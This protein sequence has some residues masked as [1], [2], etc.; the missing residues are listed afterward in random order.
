MPTAGEVIGT[1]SQLEAVLDAG[2]EN[3][4]NRQEV[5]F[6]LYNKVVVARDSYVFWVATPRTTTVIGSLHY[7]S[8]RYQDEDQTISANQV[9]LSAEREITDLNAVAPGTMWIG[10]W[11][12]SP[13]G[14]SLP[15]QYL[16]VAFSQRGFLYGPA[17][18]WHY[19]GYAVYPAMSSQVVDDE[20]D[21][22]A[23]PIVSNSLPIWLSQN[24]MAPVYPSFLV[25]DNIAPPYIVAHVEPSGT[26]AIESFPIY[27]WP[28][29]TVPDS[30][31]SPMHELASSQFCRDEVTLTMYGFNNQQAW[32][33][34][35]SLIEYSKPDD[36]PFGFANSPVIVDPKR[37][38]VE[39]AAIAQKKTLKISANYLQGAAD[40]IAR[41]LI[42]KAGI[43]TIVVEGGILV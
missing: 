1:Q 21:I 30:G 28:G 39:I 12:I 5:Q 19:I 9:V 38:Q 31:T 23:S 36:A 20:D 17:N 35:V 27:S 25:P 8:D 42:L 15:S 41:R 13:A 18:L 34:F 11:P 6:R 2:V 4:S 3:L 14:S 29:V 10:K 7:G 40:V 33:Y 43:G 37:T 32:Q 22:P 24:Q 26:T 16:Q